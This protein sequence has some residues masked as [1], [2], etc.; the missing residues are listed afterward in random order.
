[1]SISTA[2]YFSKPLPGQTESGNMGLSRSHLRIGC[3][4]AIVVGFFMPW[5]AIGPVSV[6]GYQLWRAATGFERAFSFFLYAIPV[7]GVLTVLTEFSWG[8]KQSEGSSL[9]PILAVATGAV[10]ILGFAYLLASL[11]HELAGVGG[12][13]VFWYVLQNLSQV[14]ALGAYVTLAAALVLLGVAMPESAENRKAILRA[15]GAVIV[16]W[17]AYNFITQLAMPILIFY[18]EKS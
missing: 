11:G 9:R 5:L 3:A 15:V 12:E 4:L 18:F 8:T 6:A 14:L 7:L 1:M 17:L 2:T 13:E 10:P 16:L